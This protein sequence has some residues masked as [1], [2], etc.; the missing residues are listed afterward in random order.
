MSYS[1]TLKRRKG[2]ATSPSN[3]GGKRRRK[4]RAFARGRRP[5]RTQ[6]EAQ[7][8]KK[9][10]S[11]PAIPQKQ[12]GEESM[13]RGILIRKEKEEQGLF[14]FPSSRHGGKKRGKKRSPINNNK[15]KKRFPRPWRKRRRGCS[16]SN[17]SF[18]KGE[19]RSAPLRQ[20]EKKK[21]GSRRRN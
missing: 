3:E 12:R 4:K 10:I 8:K 14:R 1:S 7:G 9:L 18:R 20:R 16:A 17:V 13:R 2:R 11:S 5:E 19:R 21:K 15:L 6:K